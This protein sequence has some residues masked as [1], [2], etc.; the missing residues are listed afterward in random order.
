MLILGVFLGFGSIGFFSNTSSYFNRYDPIDNN[1]NPILNVY[2]CYENNY[3]VDE[4]NNNG[5]IKCENKDITIMSSADQI[6]CSNHFRIKLSN[7]QMKEIY[8]PYS[9]KVYTVRRNSNICNF[10]SKK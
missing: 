2:S 8:S 6:I 4:L 9:I 1:F 5:T 7:K 3:E 10:N